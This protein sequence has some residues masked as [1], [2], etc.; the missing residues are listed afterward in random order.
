[1]KIYNTFTSQKEDFIPLEPDRVGFYL[2]GPTVYDYFHL[3]NARPF[4]VFDV[5]RRFLIY[6]GFQ[7]KYV[8]NVTDVD[9]KIINR[10]Q[11]EGVSV[12]EIAA[13]YTQAFFEDME[14]LGI[15][16]ADVHPKATEHIPEMIELIQKLLE[17]GYAYKI[18]GDVY[19]QVEKFRKY[20]RLSGKNLEELK[21][22]ARVEVDERK[23]NPLDFALWKAAKAG[24]PCWESPWGKGRPGWHIECSAMSMKYLGET[25][26]IHAGGEDLIFPH[27]ENEIAQSCAA[28]SKKFARYWMHNGFL[29]IQGEKMSKSLGN[30]LIAREVVKRH[31]P[32]VIRLFFLQ[33]HYRSPIN[34]TEE[35][36]RQTANALDRLQNTLQNIE[37]YLKD[38]PQGTDVAHDQIQQGSEF[39]RLVQYSKREFIKAM[40]DDFN[41]AAAI[42]K[43]FEMAKEANRIME[44][45][46][47]SKVDQFALAD[48]R[49][50]LLEYDQFLGILPGK[51]GLKKGEG[52]EDALVALLVQVREEL[53]K[54]KEWSLADRIR[55][56]LKELGYIIEDRREGSVWYKV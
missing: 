23:R 32:E 43:I 41:S 14:K 56:K 9:D 17:K 54:K 51:D 28:T 3:G 18:G 39:S 47:L 42:G 46:E 20:G 26:D 11:K 50:M 25:F 45:G 31:R 55:N 1:M 34:Y 30:F 22:G 16:R 33:K 53:R 15:H 10:A 37:Y 27:H 35:I 36:L 24:E 6:R 29:N 13:R 5:Y 49:R 44:K 12:A 38:S 4:I 2:C 8:M 40:E 7:V 21:A 19:F 52:D 48:F